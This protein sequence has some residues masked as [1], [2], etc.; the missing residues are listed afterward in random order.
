MTVVLGVH[1]LV[2]SLLG[3]CSVPWLLWSSLDLRRA[4]SLW[5]A[6]EP[7]TRCIQ[8]GSQVKCVSMYWGL[9]GRNRDWQERG[10]EMVL[11]K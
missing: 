5:V 4:W 8:L 6:S 11:R 3:G 1:C 7:F 2:L 10:I 9:R